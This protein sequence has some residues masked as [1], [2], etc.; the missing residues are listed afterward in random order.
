MDMIVIIREM[1]Y[2]NINVLLKTG[3]ETFYEALHNPSWTVFRQ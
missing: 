1:L 3:F 2:K